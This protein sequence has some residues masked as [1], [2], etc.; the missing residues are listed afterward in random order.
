MEVLEGKGDVVTGAGVG[1]RSRSRF[2]D[3]LEFI[4]DFG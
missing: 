3:V 1:E 4:S 2:L